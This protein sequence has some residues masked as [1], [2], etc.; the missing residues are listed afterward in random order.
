[1]GQLI[2]ADRKRKA[3]KRRQ[4]FGY[5]LNGQVL[6]HAQVGNQRLHTRITDRDN[7]AIGIRCPVVVTTLATHTEK[8]MF[9]NNRLNGRNVD[10]LTAAIKESNL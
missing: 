3:E 6:A 8:P 1:M 5:A 7:N 2:A 4:Q 10:N 9:V